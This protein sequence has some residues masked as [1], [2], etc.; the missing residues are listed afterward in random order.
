VDLTSRLARFA[1]GRPHVLVVP[2]V[3]GTAARL[4]V[5]AELARRGWPTATT[6]ADT[7][8]LIVA[9]AAGPAMTAVIGT[10]WRQV[11]APRAWAQA[12]TPDAG[13][14]GLDTALATL[15]D[16]G[17]TLDTQGPGDVKHGDRQPPASPGAED[18]PGGHDEHADHAHHGGPAHEHAV[19]GGHAEHDPDQVQDHQDQGDAHGGDH[20]GQH[21]D[22]HGAPD[23]DRDVHGDAHGGHGDAHGGHGGGMAMPGGL[24]MA[25]LGEDRDGL[26]L[27][28]LHVP[29]GP[30]LPDWPAGLVLRVVL[31]GDV[32]QQAEVEVL[33]AEQAVGPSF[34]HGPDDRRLAARELDALGRLLSVAGWPDAAI[35]ARRL[36]DDLLADAPADRLIDPAATLARRVRRSRTLRWL[37]RGIDADGVEVSAWLER[38]FDV[39]AAALARLADPSEPA[40]EPMPRV[41]PAQL[42]DVLTGLELAAA[43][44]VV[45]ALDPDTD[46]VRAPEHVEMHHAG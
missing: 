45:A 14:H 6:P 21:G 34:W 13:R 5:E 30:V 29:L 18:H 7:D 28:R 25:D 43:R 23:E 15:R 31:Q 22:A 46:A 1:A 27:D 38:R 17:A 26:A 32:V 19:S 11:P 42:P 39:V 12:A 3:G 10:L 40:A 8:L 44:L 36:R 35:R 2:A 41:D 9:G 37:L 16:P 20:G 4:Q 24:A 33:D